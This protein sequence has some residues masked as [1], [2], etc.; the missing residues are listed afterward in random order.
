MEFQAISNIN[1]FQKIGLF[2][3][4][5]IQSAIDAIDAMIFLSSNSFEAA[6]PSGSKATRSRLSVWDDRSMIEPKKR[7]GKTWENTWQNTFEIRKI[8]GNP[9][10]TR[11][12]LELVNTCQHLWS[13]LSGMNIHLPALTRYRL[14]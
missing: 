8:R 1:R 2:Q 3:L 9:R 12:K 6:R 11:W 5:L 4:I 14:H 10:K 13:I 7:T